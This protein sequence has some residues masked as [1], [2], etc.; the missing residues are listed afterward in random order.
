MNAYMCVYVCVQGVSLQDRQTCILEIY[1]L[2]LYQTG[3]LAG[4]VG[5]TETTRNQRVVKGGK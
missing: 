3:K 4:G 2:F 1:R 5:N